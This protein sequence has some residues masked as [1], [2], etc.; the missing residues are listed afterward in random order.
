MKLSEFSDAQLSRK[1][2]RIKR[3]LKNRAKR[4]ERKE[5]LTKK[6]MSQVLSNEQ[7]ALLERILDRA[8]GLANKR[9]LR[10]WAASVCSNRSDHSDESHPE[11]QEGRILRSDGRL[12]WRERLGRTMGQRISGQT[13]AWTHL[14]THAGHA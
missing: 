11:R 6:L 8:Q 10:T 1:A 14:S 3:L 5:Q 12:A 13:G 7:K 9:V 4:R 2:E